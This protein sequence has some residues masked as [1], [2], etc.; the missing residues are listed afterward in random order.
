MASE[1]K[2]L[3]SGVDLDSVMVS[4]RNL[5]ST[6]DTVSLGWTSTYEI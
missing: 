6:S 2:D 3:L 1:V 4:V 5:D